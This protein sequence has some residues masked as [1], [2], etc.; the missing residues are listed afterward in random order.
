MRHND[1]A[2]LEDQTGI[3]HLGEELGDFSDTAALVSLMDLVVSVDASLAH[4][5]GALGKAVWIILPFS[6][7][8]R[9]M[10]RRNG[11]PW[12]PSA[13]LFRQSRIEDWEVVVRRLTDKLDTYD[14]GTGTDSTTA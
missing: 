5:A 3:L 10:L 11:S 14:F 12:Y 8:W 7:D 13:R 1:R 2:T 6:P 4:L 9:W